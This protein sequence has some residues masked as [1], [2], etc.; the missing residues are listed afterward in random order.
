M[1][2]VVLIIG[3]QDDLA[4]WLTAAIGHQAVALP[5]ET[6]TAE[7]ATPLRGVA[8]EELPEAIVFTSQVPVPRALAIAADVRALR[9]DVDMSLIAATEKQIMLD[10]MR[11]GIRDV[12]PSIE[13]PAFLAGLRDRMN[14]RDQSGNGSAAPVAEPRQRV[15]FASRTVTVLSPKGG[16]GKTSIATN[17]AVALAQQSPMEVV[18]V[19]LD[20]QFG[21]L[22]TVLD[23][24]PSHTL[25]D[26]FGAGGRDSL[27][28]KTYLTVHSA[29]F[30]VMCGADS[31]AAN[32]K[33]SDRQVVELIG[34]LQT[35]FRYV[36]IDTAAGLGEATLAALECSDDAVFVST[37]DVA[38]LR[39]VRK[40]LELLG[41]LDLLPTSRFA[42]LNFA[43]KQSGL[44]VKDVEA[45][46]G[47][48]VD[49]ALPRAKE[50]TA[51][52]N[53]GVPVLLDAKNSAFSKA[54]RNLAKRIYDRASEAE[55]KQG[56][57][58]LEVA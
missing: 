49:V 25:E 18:L 13:D 20:L 21:D 12:S 53:R 43:D 31:P 35:Q 5:V 47:V 50:V 16:V 19:D 9:P 3:A 48:P 10:A 15:D 14:A 37:M 45:M 41:E 32:D 4:T 56:H 28:L 29:G 23:L 36:I 8:P 42:L 33:V 7:P 58:R 11:A 2:K 44:R 51:A 1:S 26:A 24:Q 46:L 30:Y 40:E 39:S 55:E 34:Q 17:L 52:T 27:L 57:K 6:V 54:I 38:C 22:S